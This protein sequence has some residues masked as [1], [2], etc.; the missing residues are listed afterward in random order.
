MAMQCDLQQMCNT[1]FKSSVDDLTALC[2]MSV[3]DAQTGCMGDI[4]LLCTQVSSLPSI[5]GNDW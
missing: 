1:A 4:Q 5:L 3:P 2:K